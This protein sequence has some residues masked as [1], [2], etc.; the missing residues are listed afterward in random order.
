MV[1]ILSLALGNPVLD[2]RVM[3]RTLRA[4]GEPTSD[5]SEFGGVPPANMGALKK[6]IRFGSSNPPMRVTRGMFRFAKHF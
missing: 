5:F 6:Q 2:Q 4:V 3:S 1:I